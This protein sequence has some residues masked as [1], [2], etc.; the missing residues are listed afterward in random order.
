MYKEPAINHFAGQIDHYEKTSKIQDK[1][2]V[3][4]L[5][6]AKLAIES[7]VNNE[8]LAYQYFLIL[9][10]LEMGPIDNRILSGHSDILNVDRAP[11]L[12]SAAENLYKKDLYGAILTW[13]IALE[14][15]SRQLVG[16]EDEDNPADFFA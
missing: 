15:Q 4:S 7:D 2:T 10:P 1:G 9:F 16:L 13:R 11:M 8:D 14:D 12:T 6:I 3:N 5:R